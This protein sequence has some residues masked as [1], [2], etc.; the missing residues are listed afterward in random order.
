MSA[1]GTA[2]Y[3]TGDVPK[4][5]FALGSRPGP[6]VARRRVGPAY[7]ACAM[8]LVGALGGL[9][10]CTPDPIFARVVSSPLFSAVYTFS[11]LGLVG[12]TTLGFLRFTLLHGDAGGTRL[13]LEA[14]RLRIAGPEGVLSAPPGRV[15]TRPVSLTHDARGRSGLE[16]RFPDG[17][18]VRIVLG[19]ESERVELDE[20]WDFTLREDDLAE[21]RQRLVRPTS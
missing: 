15:S 20:P 2:A 5:S 8:T 17:E 21:L 12:L 16:L 14:E 10:W 19:E 4:L 7:V 1:R 6:G 11:V 3:R 13:S 9:A 18:V